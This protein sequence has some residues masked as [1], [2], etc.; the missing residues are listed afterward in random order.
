MRKIKFIL[1]L[2]ALTLFLMV[3]GIDA[4]LCRTSS[5]Y[6]DDCFKVENGYYPSYYSK[7]KVVEVYK[8]ES[9][10][11]IF[12]GSNNQFQRNLR[13]YRSSN[14]H[15]DTSRNYYS[16]SFQV[17]SRGYYGNYNS[18]YYYDNYYGDYY[19]NYYG[20]YW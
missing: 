17:P 16:G 18:G 2:F 10:P 19:G 14:Y 9:R 7:P 13:E 12:T 6:Y 3:I 4:R 20:Y 15:P 1:P 8:T 11:K 5:G